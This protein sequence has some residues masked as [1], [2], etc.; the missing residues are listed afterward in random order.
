MTHSYE[1]LLHNSSRH[2]LR[3]AGGSRCNSPFVCFAE[4]LVDLCRKITE[5][6]AK[7]TKLVKVHKNRPKS[8]EGATL[9]E[10]TGSGTFEVK[11]ICRTN[12]KKSLPDSK[13]NLCHILFDMRAILE[14]YYTNYEECVN[15]RPE[16]TAHGR[17]GPGVD[18]K[19][20][21]LV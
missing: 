17:M 4:T 13:R 1:G 8:L 5:N 14:R 12:D 9:V 6:S 20:R 2:R 16:M 21:F 11:K 19:R 18:L 10:K 7:S 3:D 15:I